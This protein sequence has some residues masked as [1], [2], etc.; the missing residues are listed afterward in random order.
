[1]QTE[2]RDAE[3]QHAAGLAL[4]FKNSNVKVHLGE[5]ACDR[6]ARRAG[7]DNGNLT[8]Q[9][10]GG[11]R[12]LQI[13]LVS[14]VGNKHFQTADFNTTFFVCKNAFCFTLT[15]VR[16]NAAADSRQVAAFRDNFIGH[17][18]IALAQSTDEAGNII[19]NGTAGAAQRTSAV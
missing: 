16:T 11:L 8:A 13:I 1:M 18:D 2:F 4:C 19:F 12:R 5:V 6:Q 10:A 17:A 7:A 9:L 14:E 3:Q 15:L